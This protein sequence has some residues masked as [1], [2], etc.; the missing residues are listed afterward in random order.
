MYVRITI[1]ATSRKRREPN[2]SALPNR[3]APLTAP[4][5]CWAARIPSDLNL[6]QPEGSRVLLDESLK[7]YPDHSI[8]A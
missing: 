1:L 3:D 8:P 5:P 4:L 6:S 7:T 2:R